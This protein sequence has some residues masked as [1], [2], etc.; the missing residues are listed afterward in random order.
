MKHML[1]ANLLA[2][3][4]LAQMR[5]SRAGGRGWLRALDKVKEQGALSQIGRV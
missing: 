5:Q 1:C 2:H 4:D 3:G